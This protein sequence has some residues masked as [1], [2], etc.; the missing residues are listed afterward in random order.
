MDF[1]GPI[2]P[3]TRSG[4]RYLLVVVDNATR[5][6]EAVAMSSMRAG[7]VAQELLG[8]FSRVGVPKV[9][10]SDRGSNFTSQLLTEFEKRLGATPRF[11]SPYHPAANGQCERFNQTLKAMLRSVMQAQPEN[12]DKL[13]SPVLFA[14]R[15]V[16][17]ETTGFSPFE[18]VYGRTVR[19]PLRILRESWTQEDE[20][21]GGLKPSVVEYLL[22][23]RRTL[24]TCAEEA[25]K[26]AA[27][28]Q[29]D[30]KR[31][32]DRHS[33]A[34]SFTEGQRVLVLMPSST[35][36][37]LATWQG[38]FP[39]VRRV[40]DS[41][42]TVDLGSRT[43]TLHV[44]M[45]KLFVE[46]EE[47]GKGPG[48]KIGVGEG[49]DRGQV[50]VVVVD[51]EWVE[52]D[53]GEVC[54]LVGESMQ[55]PGV[56]CAPSGLSERQE[57]QLDELLGSHGDVFRD[58]PG[59]THL[60]QHKIRLSDET[61]VVQRAYRVPD[62]LK[63]TL[64]SEIGQLLQLGLIE[65][66]ESPYASPVVYVKKRDGSLRLCVDYRGVNAKSVGDAYPMGDL[67]GIVDRVSGSKY[68]ST[69]DLNKAYWQ[70]PME[71]ESREKTAFRTHVGLFQFR[72]MPFGLTGAPATC[73]RLLDKV[74]RGAQEY[75]T[76]YLDDVA[77]FSD[78]WE[79][80]L[81]HL[82]DVLRRFREAGL[83]ANRNK[84][85]FV[86]PSLKLLGFV[87]GGGKLKP[88][89]DKI[90]AVEA[91]TRPINKTGVRAFLG[92]TGYYRRFIPDYARL[93]VPLTDL[94]RKLQPDKVVWGAAQQAAF[95]ALKSAL[96]RGPVLQ[97]PDPTKPYIL[98]TDASQ[99]GIGAVL[100][101]VDAD[102]VEHPV[103][104]ASRKLL[105]RETRYS[106][107]ERECL[108]IVWAIENFQ[109][110]VYGKPLVI[111]TDHNPL[112]WLKTVENRS[113]RL[114]R[115]ALSLQ[116]YWVNVQY[117][118]GCSNGNADGLSRVF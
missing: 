57:A 62:A 33:R 16:P 50:N 1:V 108:A 49:S 83:V 85:Q 100:S 2:E 102:G 27:E 82:G 72:V 29:A 78:T 14:Y 81:R 115:W 12:W 15:E 86:R 21:E 114:T 75:A 28:A 11:T 19:G 22:D 18:L 89:S 7:K 107:V 55:T 61:P 99:Y 4:K 43:S 37:M 41:N 66:S 54:P 59:K 93:A 64:E 117:R 13:I 32:Y 6:P 26:H 67:S 96:V 30:Y 48:G 52:D 77:I 31:W 40:N 70:I 97:A 20:P 71:P 95:E 92:L 9:I 60:I 94:T 106:T 111:Q 47:A 3:P 35:H 53:V 90:A 51:E 98:Q 104:Y 88:D 58:T 44:N 23:L 8:I 68:I 63:S 38:P 25:Q 101:Q 73:Q 24:E 87:L 110:L 76:A 116:P 118:R 112:V 91:F 80:H 56:R 39:V 84:C 42:Y 103:Y 10:R 109:S 45:L 17:N 79:D 113:P 46:R 5:W 69:M 74:L 65:E 36:K 34:R 105:P